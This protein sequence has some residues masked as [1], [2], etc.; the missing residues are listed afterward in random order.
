VQALVFPNSDEIL[1]GA[2]PLEQM[3]LMVHPATMSIAGVHGEK[4][5]RHIK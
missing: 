3:D 4:Q 2:F 1:I 5:V